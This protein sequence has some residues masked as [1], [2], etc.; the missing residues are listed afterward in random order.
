MKTTTKKAAPKR[1]NRLVVGENKIHL[2]DQLFVQAFTRLAKI[3]AA[4][5]IL[6]ARQQAL[7]DGIQRVVDKAA[8][9]PSKDK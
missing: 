6:E 1:K 9:A 3:E 5:Q 8:A 7:V 2:I 4:I